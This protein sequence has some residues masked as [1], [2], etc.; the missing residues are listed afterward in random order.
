VAYGCTY[1]IAELISSRSNLY[2]STLT[3]RRNCSP[4]TMK[5][6]ERPEG[7]RPKQAIVSE[8][9]YSTYSNTT[10]SQGELSQNNSLV[11]DRC[12]DN[13][14][15]QEAPKTP[16]RSFFRKRQIENNMTRPVL[17]F[18]HVQRAPRPLTIKSSCRQHIRTLHRQAM[19]VP[20]MVAGTKSLQL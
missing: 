3:V 14:A 1:G 5:E 7:Q 10:S 13:S 8:H 12:T 11:G 2:L 4:T 20:G 19:H 6:R 17:A 15:T 9:N 18:T 16:M